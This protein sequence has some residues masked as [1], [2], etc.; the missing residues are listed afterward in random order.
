MAYKNSYDEIHE[1][2]IKTYGKANHCEFCQTEKAKRYE[3]CLK[4]GEVHCK[5]IKCYIELCTSCHRRYDWTDE[6]SK[7]CSD[8]NKGVNNPNYGKKAS[9]KKLENMSNSLKGRKIT[10]GNEI[11]KSLKGRIPW[12][13]G[14][15]KNR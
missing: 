5:D 8:R 13:K 14:L 2:L 3:H 11:S 15:R 7:Q 10:W 1:W 12:N 4:K 9:K 6:K